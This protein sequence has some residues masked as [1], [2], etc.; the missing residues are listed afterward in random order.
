MKSIQHIIEK[1]DDN[2]NPIVV[3]ELR[4][5]VRSRF[6]TGVLMIFLVSL[7]IAMALFITTGTTMNKGMG[8]EAFSFLFSVFM[9]PSM[10]FVPAYTGT[11]M[12]RERAKEN[13]DLLFI[14]TISPTAIIRGKLFAGI[15]IDILIFSAFLPF[16]TLTY[17][18][19][20]VDLPSVFVI[21]AM[22]FIAITIAT[23]FALFIASVSSNRIFIFRFFMGGV[24]AGLI[25]VFCMFTIGIGYGMLHSG[26]G[27]RLG[28]SDFWYPAAALLIIAG[29]FSIAIHEWSVAAISHYSSAKRP[30]AFRSIKTFAC[31][32]TG[33]T[34]AVLILCMIPL[35]LLL[36]IEALR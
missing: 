2:L 12:F 20:G 23:Q 4:Q 28:S 11:R 32:I 18:L 6:V 8:R 29:L 24:T 36:L 21:M 33:V 25:F 30:M 14:S 31:I 19:R 9:V 1:I 7:L 16:M 26:V 3:K 13:M 27:S 5:A 22:A 17:L 15:I 34:I 10:L 35:V